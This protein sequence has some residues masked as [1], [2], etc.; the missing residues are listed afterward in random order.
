MEEGTQR[1]PDYREARHPT[2]VYSGSRVEGRWVVT[3][4]DSALPK[5]DDNPRALEESLSRSVKDC[6]P[7]FQWGD[8]SPGARQLAI[9]LLLDVSGDAGIAMLWHERFAQTYVS[10]LGST[11]TVPEI[12]IALC[13]YCFDNARPGS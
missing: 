5:E 6:C 11:W 12:D 10:Q 8:D 2:R 1:L 3:V 9:A 7:A 13:L 4:F